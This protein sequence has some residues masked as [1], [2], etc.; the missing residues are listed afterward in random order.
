MD[1]DMPMM[2]GVEATE[3]LKE[4]DKTKNIPII[5]SSGYHTDS[6][7][8]EEALSKG[9]ID[10]IRKPID[11][12]ELIAR[13]HSML[14]FVDSFKELIKQKELNHQQE[15]LH[16]QKELSQHILS[17]A[18]QNEYLSFVNEEL[19]RFIEFANAKLKKKLFDLIEANN[20]KIQFTAW[21][22][23]EEQFD[24]AYDKFY[25]KLTKKFPEL[26]AN[27]RKLCGLLRLNMSSKEIAQITF[28]EP[29]SVDVARYR[30][31]QKL[32]LEKDDNLTSF[33]SNL[34]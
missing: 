15:I 8:I 17:T 26:S 20:K 10:F 16:K 32:G 21:E 11:K 2:N 4:D 24:E 12:V 29:S 27:D 28:Q 6:N 3:R 30:L 23:F 9:A 31:R 7:A 34:R 5:I 1:W 18:Q 13:V 19:K 25:S 22:Q 14:Q 33:L